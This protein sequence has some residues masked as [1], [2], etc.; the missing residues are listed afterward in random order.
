MDIE[1]DLIAPRIID[2]NEVFLFF[3]GNLMGN[4]ALFDCQQSFTRRDG[5]HIGLQTGAVRGCGF[6][7]ERVPGVQTDVMMIATGADERGLGAHALHQLEAEDTAIKLE[8][9]IKVRHLEVDV[10]N[11]DPRIDGFC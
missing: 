9:A 11:I 5:D 7:S 8:R 10:T 3:K 2:P 1:E 6:R 4:Q